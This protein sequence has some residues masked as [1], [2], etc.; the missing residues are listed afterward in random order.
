M[1]ARE[2]LGR[3]NVR[4]AL[5]ELGRPLGL[6]L[7]IVR[8]HGPKVGDPIDSVEEITMALGYPRF[9]LTGPWIGD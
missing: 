8:V 5:T 9:Q 4:A 1:S 3:R 6:Q 7:V 2:A